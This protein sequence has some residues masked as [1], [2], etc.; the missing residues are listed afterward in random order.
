[1][2]TSWKDSLS[3]AFTPRADDLALSLELEES[4]PPITPSRVIMS[5]AALTFI[6]LVWSAIARVDEVARAVG[7]IEPL[8]DVVAVQHLEGGII[9]DILIDDGE[10]VTRGQVLLRLAPAS[11]RAKLEQLIARRD[12]LRLSI[13][14]EMAI[15]GRASFPGDA[16]AG[17][18]D[19][20]LEQTEFLRARSSEKVVRLRVADA[21]IA[22][23]EARIASL[24]D[25][26]G[27]AKE[28]SD[29]A[30]EERRLQEDLFRRG[31]STRDRLNNARIRAVSARRDLVTL[32]AER[33]V[34]HEQLTV[35][36]LRRDEFEAVSRS[37]ALKTTTELMAELAEIDA[38][39]DE[40]RD[41]LAR[42]DVTAP[43]DGVVT[44]LQVKSVNSV[45]A[46]GAPLLEIVPI[47][48]R[49]IVSARVAPRD[50]ALV[51]V[52]G[53]VKVRVAA[54][55]F[56]TFGA[57]PGVVER[58]SPSTFQTE[59]SGPYYRVDVALQRDHFGDPRYGLKVLPGMTVEADIQG[60][61][62]SLLSY[63]IKPVSRGWTRAFG[64]A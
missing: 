3:R 61:S 52:G 28:E 2:T 29:F 63:L 58:I 10:V 34:A 62:K 17:N 38:A 32:E 19:Q 23:S 42:L 60:R 7:A 33:K 1:M 55:D 4:N 15:E 64:E 40:A 57:L 48:D 49:M 56:A 26:L 54:F 9:E 53:P 12:G 25:Q 31:V 5:L 24:A 22:E 13:A 8:G 44:R 50:I 6:A 47:G 51:K 30:E 11:A 35:A 27:V 20:V 45:V 18:A 39:V 21:Q 16:D 41:Q 36:R 43:V 14:R 59:E 46:P 37:E